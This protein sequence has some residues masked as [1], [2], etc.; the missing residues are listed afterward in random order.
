MINKAS[1]IR[2]NLKKCNKSNLQRL[3][4]HKTE[5]HIYASIEK[6]GKI[7]ASVSSKNIDPK[8]AK[9]YNVSGAALVG[10][11]IGQEALKK[12]LDKKVY[13]DRGGYIYHGRI[14]ALAD[15]AREYLEF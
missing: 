12:N 11:M 9:S 8:V 13:F 3:F 10:K 14:K 1:R 6:D 15:G 5:K 2:Y 7:L 4:V